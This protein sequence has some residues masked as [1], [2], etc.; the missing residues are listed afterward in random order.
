MQARVFQF[1][2]QQNIIQ[3]VAYRPNNIE[4]TVYCN[5][6]NQALVNKDVARHYKEQ[7]DNFAYTHKH[8]LKLFHPDDSKQGIGQ[9]LL[10]VDNQPEILITVKWFGT[11]F[12]FDCN[13]VCNEINAQ[14]W[15]RRRYVYCN[16]QLAVTKHMIK[17]LGTDLAIHRHLVDDITDIPAYIS[18]KRKL[19]LSGNSP[20][21]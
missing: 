16:G 13:W 9:L 2:C 21:S 14:V 7:R 17:E 1:Q 11:Q 20:H 3:T 6:V 12:T 5:G 15:G 4:F 19:E 8:N 10:Q 18:N